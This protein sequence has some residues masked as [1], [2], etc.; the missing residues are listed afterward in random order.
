MEND[1]KPRLEPVPRDLRPLEA[2]RAASSAPADE[3]EPPN[4]RRRP[5]VIVGVIVGAMLLAI[6]G[7]LLA[8]M[9]EQGTDDAQ[10]AADMVPIGTRVAGQVVKVQRASRTSSCTRARS[11][12]RSIRP[13]TPRA[14]KQAEADLASQQAQ[15][16]AADAQVAVIEAGSKGG[17]SSARAALAGSTVSVGSAEAQLQAAQRRR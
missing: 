16:A 5:Y 4:S 3:A 1:S 10:V 7:Y 8:T 14:C 6:G 17:L 12:P 9:G 13:T 2:S 11:S 15:A